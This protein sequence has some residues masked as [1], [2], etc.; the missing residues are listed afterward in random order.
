MFKARY[1]RRRR[2]LMRAPVLPRGWLEP[3]WLEGL[4]RFAPTEVAAAAPPPCCDDRRRRRGMPSGRDW[5]Q[6]AAYAKRKRQ[7]GLYHVRNVCRVAGCSAG[8]VR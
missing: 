5:A 7:A 4:A 6:E 1:V 2:R 8:W 3:G